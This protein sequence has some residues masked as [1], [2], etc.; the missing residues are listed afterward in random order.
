MD[1][2]PHSQ[3]QRSLFDDAS[4]KTAQLAET[5]RQINQTLGRF[6]VRSGCT[7]PLQDGHS[8]SANDYDICDI[9]GKSCF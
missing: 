7:L 1:P 9:Y 2:S 5:K 8:D 4:P 3:R 6:A